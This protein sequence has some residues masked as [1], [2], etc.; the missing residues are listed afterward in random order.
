MCCAALGRRLQVALLRELGFDAVW[1]Y[2]TTDTAGEL[3]PLSFHL[4]ACYSAHLARTAA[5]W[6]PA[7]MPARSCAGGTRTRRH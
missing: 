4:H 7:Q 1:N 3:C 6:L 2:K 5:T